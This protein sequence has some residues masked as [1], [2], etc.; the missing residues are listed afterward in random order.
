MFDTRPILMQKMSCL[1]AS[2][3]KREW[4]AGYAVGVSAV[5][6]RGS[7]GVIDVALLRFDHLS[8]LQKGSTIFSSEEKVF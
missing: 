4:C 2:L 7:F 5:S 1:L 8:L 6:G 3:G